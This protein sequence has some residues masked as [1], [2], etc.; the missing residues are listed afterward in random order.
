[1]A[2]V[3]STSRATLPGVYI[4]RIFRPTPTGLAGFN[5][6]PCLV[7]K[8]S[9]LMTM[10]NVPI[11]RSYINQYPLSISDTA[12]HVASLAFPA[13]NDQTISQLQKTNGQPIPASQW[14]FT[15]SQL[16]SGVYNQI[17]VLPEVFDLNAS[18][19]LNYQSTSTTVQDV[20][21]FSD[22]REIRMV[23]DA[24]NQNRYVENKNFY[25]PGSVSDA[26]AGEENANSDAKEFSAVVAGATNA[27]TATMTVAG[28]FTSKYNRTY[29][30][31]ITSNDQTAITADVRVTLGSGGNEVAAPSPIHSTL[32]VPEEQKVTFESGG[33][34]SAEF[35]D[36][37][38]GDVITLTLNDA[39]MTARTDDT[40]T[41]TGLGPSLI[42]TSS[43]FS[44][45][46]QFS[47]FSAVT[48]TVTNA[49]AALD[50]RIDAGY[51]GT[52]NRKYVVHCVEASGVSPS[53][54]AKFVWTGYGEDPVSS[55]DFSITEANSSNLDVDIEE[56]IKVD[57]SFG[58]VNFAVGDEFAFEA[59]AA[60]SGVSAKDS[61]DYKLT[62]QA[63]PAGAVQFQYE[64][65]TPE[66]RFGLVNTTGPAGVLRLPG[67]VDLYVRNIGTSAEE[68]RH[69][70]GDTWGFSTVNEEKIDW[71]L[72]SRTSE[73][74]KTTEVMTD[75]LGIITG[76]VGSSYVILQN[77]PSTLQYVQDTVSQ[78]HLTATSIDGQP[79]VWFTE[80][81]IHDIV[82]H[83]EYAGLEPAPGNFYFVTANIVRPENMYNTPMMF[84]TYDAAARILGPSGTNNDLLIAAELALK[85]NGAPGIFICQAKDSDG[86]GHYSSID[87]NEAIF[88][89]EHVGQLTDVIVLNSSGSLNTALLSNER[90]NDPF[91]RK[92]RALW[93]GLP[94]GTV[95]GNTDV[96][97]TIVFTAK[98]TLQVF[99]DNHAH[100]TRVLVANNKA[101]KTITLSD[102]SQTD[103]TLDGS[104]IAVAV[105][106]KNASFSSPSATLLRSNISGFKSMN[107]YSEPEM[108]TL[109]EA[110]VVYIHNQGSADSPVWR[111]EDS[112]TVDTSS[113]DNNEISV[114]IN[115][116]MYVTRTVRSAM[117]QS[118]IAITPQS[119]E[120]GIALVQTYL[121]D[122]LLQMVSRGIIG[123]Y[124]TE[125]GAARTIDPKVDVEVFADRSDKRLYNFKYWWMGIYPVKRLFGLYSV[126]KIFG[127]AVNA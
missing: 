115:Q 97:G 1:M 84:Q 42:E 61:R 3:L 45:T 6:L 59:L 91:E 106:A 16:G 127:T 60:R 114:A 50:L 64:T 124:Q 34:S 122:L 41:F 37:A 29:T 86:D 58:S 27:G 92:E 46:S 11:R 55:G 117:D 5:R 7:G 116:T 38:T 82:V 79:I 96:P 110:S 33:P 74:I 78:G 69:A 28:D 43:A 52:N 75:A 90:M 2:D 39:G 72:R 119:A 20:L 77:T 14:Q 123:Q 36:V 76:M 31:K 125:S 107:T 8:G 71:T 87:I 80:A 118:L 104:F 24:E 66:G 105:A 21:P 93:V 9:R 70:A 62:V 49:S 98:R 26:V 10:Y 63:A 99:G 51:K 94:I 54:T 112:V 18:Y 57:L 126:D 120:A 23:G 35:T 68:N 65:N 108:L 22:L 113:P 109:T 83:Y 89:T 100:G 47:T 53:R 15:E 101:V 95:I 30:V 19:V 73:T 81:P 48:E 56:G 44:N 4:G 12:P 13:V 121:V 111:V 32:N 85:D 40:F 17:L 102:G 25:I 88:A 103:V 67:G